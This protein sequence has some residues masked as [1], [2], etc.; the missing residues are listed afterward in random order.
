MKT[1]KPL[2]LSIVLCSAAFS[3]FLFGQPLNLSLGPNEETYYSLLTSIIELAPYDF[4][5]RLYE[6]TNHLLSVDNNGRSMLSIAAQRSDDPRVVALLMRHRPS[7]DD[8]DDQGITP[9]MYAVLGERIENARLLLSS[10]ADV[11]Y[12]S[13]QGF[14]A[15]ILAAGN[16][17]NPELVRLL[18]DA[19]ADLRLETAFGMSVHDA[20][21]NNPALKDS[22]LAEEIYWKSPPK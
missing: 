9:L 13:A 2:S 7:L 17:A 6:E 16:N 18:L 5:E 3:N 4:L 15:L 11:D 19:G 14:T 21:M 22:V 10:G 8:P 20:I 1:L 12:Q